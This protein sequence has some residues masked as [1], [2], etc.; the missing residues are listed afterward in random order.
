MKKQSASAKQ[1]STLFTPAHLFMMVLGIVI[2]I[3]CSFVLLQSTSGNEKRPEN[4][5]AQPALH[6]ISESIP[7]SPLRVTMSIFGNVAQG[8]K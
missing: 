2:A 3:M 4:Y 8:L 7:V 5:S 1:N 6:V